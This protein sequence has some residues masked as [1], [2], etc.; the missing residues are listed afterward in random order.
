[1]FWQITLFEIRYWLRSWMLWIF[2]LVIAL[3][4]FLAV[5]T[6]NI[7]LGFVLSNTYHN[8]PFVIANY[9]PSRDCSRC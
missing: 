2:F 8:A 5:S 4:V 3:A 7:T 9:T 6:D 1:M